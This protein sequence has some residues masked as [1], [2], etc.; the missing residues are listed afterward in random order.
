LKSRAT[1]WIKG[2]RRLAVTLLTLTLA[3]IMAL[4]VIPAHADW[5][6]DYPDVEGT[7][8]MA[9]GARPVDLDGTRHPRVGFN[10]LIITTQTGKAITDATLEH[11]GTDIALTGMVGPGS[12][13]TIVLGGT[14]SDG[15]VTA[16]QGR[17]LTNRAGEVVSLSGRMMT[18]VTQDGSRWDD[19]AD[20]TSEISV[21]AYHSEPLSCLLTGGTLANPETILFHNPVSRMR[22]SQLANLRSDQLGFWFNLQ[23]TK[24]PGPQMML[25]FAPYERGEPTTQTYY[26]GGTSGLVDI[27][28]M[29]YQAPYTGDGTWVECAITSESAICGYYGNDPTDFTAFDGGFAGENYTLAEI[30]AA[31]NAEAAMTAG[32][33]SASNWMLTMV[34]VEL[35]E[36]GAR[37]CYI[38]DVT[39]GGMT[40]SLEPNSYYAGFRAILQE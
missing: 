32:E 16:I 10:R 14:D 8:L 37:T 19:S 11:M 4:A 23:D 5:S 12:R 29:P 20:G 30:E 35:W 27:T 24:S 38:D 34:S 31:I 22:L 15:T 25:R 33:D 6:L 36:G 28:I 1:N 21:A 2:H 3:L 7:Y 13:P 9:G 40:Y 39:I 17:V 18:Y 26:G